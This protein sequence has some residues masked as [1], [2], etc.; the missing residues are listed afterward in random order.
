MKKTLKFIDNSLALVENS[1]IVLIVA[2][3][4]V[5]SFLQVFLRNFF[6]YGILWGDI[7]LRHMVLWVGFIGASLATRDEKHINIDVLGRISPERF[8][9]YL[10]TIVDLFTMLV[11]IALAHAAYGFL[12]YEIEANT[13]LFNNIP[14]WIFQIIIPLGFALIAFRFFL[15]I[16]ERISGAASAEPRIKQT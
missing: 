8:R 7:F 10:R 14:A 11:C 13:I 5:M 2:I 15:K 9:P 16:L 4:V 3:M 6:D 12:Q 1:L